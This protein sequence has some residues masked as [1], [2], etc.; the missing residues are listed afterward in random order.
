MDDQ[1][2][3]NE[4]LVE[5]NENLARLD[6]EMIE[7]E[8][9]P[10]DSALLASIF[11]TI[12]TIKGTCGFL[13]FSILESVTHVAENLLSQIR[14]GEKEATAE[15]V[16]LILSTVDAVRAVLAKIEATGSEG[17][18]TFSVL[19]QRL[20]TACEKPTTGQEPRTELPSEPATLAVPVEPAEAT[21]SGDSSAEGEGVA[22]GKTSIADS[23]IRV[24]VGL[25]DKLMT[26]VGELVLARNQILQATSQEEDPTL[27]ATSQR[28][29][30]ITSELQE[31][32]MRTRMQPIGTV[33]GKLP[34][35]VRDLAVSCGKKI[36]LEMDGAGTELDKTILEAIKD[37]LTH[38]VRNSCDHG[39]E[40]PE[41]RVS[42]G[43]P[44]TGRISLRAFHEGGHVNIEIAD[45]GAGINLEKVRRRAIQK[46]L[47]HS[48]QAERM[49]DREIVN[50]VFLPGFS[51]AERVTNIS[52]R[53]VG[54]DVVRTNI[55]K[56]GGSVELSSVEDEGSSVKIKIPLTLAI[57]PGLV[58]Y[59]GGERFVIPQV[60][61]LELVRLEG[62]A[63]RRGIEDIHG[64][65]V[66]RSRGDL[67]PIADLNSLLGLE[68]SLADPDATNVVVVQAE[69]RQFGLVVDGISDTQEIVVKPLGKQFKGTIC[70]AGATIMGDG[71]VALI[72]DVTGIAQMAGMLSTARAREMKSGEQDAG[73]TDRE[74]ILLFRAGTL[75]RVAIPLS[76]VARL[77]EIPVSRIERATGRQVCQY[78]GQILPLTRL[79]DYLN[80]SEGTTEDME[81]LRVIVVANGDRS[82]GLI[83]DEIVDIVEDRITRVAG[84][85]RPGFLGSAVVGGLVADFIDV[86]QIVSSV[87]P[88]WFDSSYS[89]R[90]S[91][92]VLAESSILARAILRNELKMAGYDVLEAG[93]SMEALAWLTKRRVDA[94]VLAADMPGAEIDALLSAIQ[95]DQ[96]LARVPILT[97]ASSRENPDW[98][99]SQRE[100]TARQIKFDR[101]AMLESL[102]NLTIA[103]DG[104]P[105]AAAIPG[106][107]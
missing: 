72:L 17:D 96:D 106:R 22:A 55:E 23:T 59:S 61:L 16:S 70:Y 94:M 97:L 95:K 100:N 7:L 85:S 9:R 71:K 90:P 107:H 5:S 40:S 4:F 29:N 60:S 28:L 33:W 74:A 27:H 32:V 43:K 62:E 56:I 65:T 105:N 15:R 2:V 88:Q 89:R 24:D 36:Q 30:L 11:R 93:S 77:E 44:A 50:L 13:G 80:S 35:V 3:I 82:V 57:I 86:H 12:H 78:R 68:G 18:D 14:S 75:N 25:L 31:N 64:T 67:L 39:I 79:S 8:Q 49:N 48:E 66:Y 41:A 34:R 21:V 101:E 98:P 1:E 47:V 6:Q 99:D 54:M 38:I 76:L 26:L 87:D 52:G 103:I 84:P 63:R 10:K 20:Q 91:T 81:P 19:R 53:G 104:H 46:G 37:P 83:V 58:V 51:T 45:D 73:T 42:S 102:K 92:V 69:N